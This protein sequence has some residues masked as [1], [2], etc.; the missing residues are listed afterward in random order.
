VNARQ[1][2]RC[3]DRHRVGDGGA[4]VTALGDV[5]G[6]AEPVHHLRPRSR[7]A[8]WVPADLGRL[9][10][11][12]V[13]GQRRQHQ[14]ERVV[15]AAAVR[16][17]VGERADDLEH[18]EDRAGPAVRDD[19]RQRVLVLRLDVDEVDAKPVDLGGE[20]RQRA[21]LRLARAP[22]VTGAPVGHQRLD[23]RQLHALRPIGDGLLAGLACGRDAPL[24][25]GQVFV[26]HVDL[27][28]ADGEVG[29]GRAALLGSHDKAGGFWHGA[30]F[31]AV[32]GM[33]RAALRRTAVVVPRRR[34]G[35]LVRLRGSRSGC[36]RPSRSSCAARVRTRRGTP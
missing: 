19:Q 7:G 28:R 27:E 30:C 4:D 23:R 25:L 22:V 14:V 2:V 33:R 12:A 16:G 35:R 32:C 29:H 17:R 3:L 10:G 13:A 31:S 8:D 26:W 21:Q 36:G 18:L 1:P 6:V 9:I 34:S 15:S 20:L 5:A 11:E 24:K